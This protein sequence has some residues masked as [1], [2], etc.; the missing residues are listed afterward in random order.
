MGL[1]LEE[2]RE[3]EGLPITGRI[4]AAS[5]DNITLRESGQTST[6]SL[7]TRKRMLTPKQ[8]FVDQGVAE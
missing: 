4:G 6:W 5:V 3:S 1:R 2:G 7:V 8:E